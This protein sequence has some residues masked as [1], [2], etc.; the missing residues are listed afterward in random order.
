MSSG[1]HGIAYTVAALMAVGLVA[2]GLYLH[3]FRHG[4]FPW[5]EA[6]HV[7]KIMDMMECYTDSACYAEQHLPHAGPFAQQLDEALQ[8]ASDGDIDWRQRFDV[9]TP[10]GMAAFMAWFDELMQVAPAID[11]RFPRSS[12]HE[13][14]IDFTLGRA[15]GVEVRMG[16][17][18][19]GGML[20]ITHMDGLCEALQRISEWKQE[21]GPTG[22][23]EA[24]AH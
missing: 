8:C 7:R 5:S 12:A 11:L 20:H 1:K 21:C 3:S 6:A 10:E 14:S 15:H 23:N 16:V 19:K 17:E 9:T 22:E 2:A 24:V 13:G 18:E 4:I